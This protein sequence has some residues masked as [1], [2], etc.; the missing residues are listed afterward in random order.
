MIES[1]FA[2]PGTRERHLST[3]LLKERERYLAHVQQ[4]GASL[5]RV[6]SIA[7]TLVHAVRLLGMSE[8]RSIDPSEVMA[9]SAT[10]EKDEMY[11]MR[12]SGGKYSA[13]KFQGITRGWL[14]FLGLLSKRNI[15]LP[16]LD[17]VFAQ[18][19]VDMQATQR[20]AAASIA[21]Y[22]ERIISFLAWFQKNQEDFNDLSLGQIDSYLGE[23]HASGWRPKSIAAACCALRNFIRYCERRGWCAP[24]IATGIFSPR[25][26]NGQREPRGPSWRDVRRL[27]RPALSGGRVELRTRVAII[28]CAVY[29][30]RRSEV[31]NMRLSDIDWYRE[32]FTLRRSKNGRAQMFPIQ[33]ELGE[34]LIEYLKNGR[35]A[36]SCQNVLVTFTT[37][38]RPMRS[39]TVTQIISA[40][41]SVLNISSQN[42]GAHALRHSCATQLLKNG[43]SLGEIADFLGHRGINSVSI[44]AKYD[45]RSLR[46]VAAFSLA[47]VL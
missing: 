47:S 32:T 15:L 22:Q 34:A 38:Y 7:A 44:Y 21:S 10:W 6:K 14:R 1:M 40:R 5:H 18:Y 3:P 35:P 36:C 37:P 41:M 19:L 25:V 31:V 26:H 39:S 33:D 11:R 45:P 9:A 2:W 29:G 4:Q 27:L 8:A 24:A 28:L 17:S 43:S 30:L 16:P 23:L 42:M 46:T 20:L 12:G 13:R